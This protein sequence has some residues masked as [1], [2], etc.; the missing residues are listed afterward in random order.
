MVANHVQVRG[1][2]SSASDLAGFDSATRALLKAKDDV[3]KGKVDLIASKDQLI[4]Q[5][6]DEVK[7]LRA[8]LASNQKT[9]GKQTTSTVQANSNQKGGPVKR[10][11]G[12]PRKIPI[13]EE[14][15]EDTE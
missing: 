7:N 8:L 1:A 11:R 5:L 2:N 6:Q 15:D 10:G 9:P 4:A 12:R 13:P 14:S 3:I